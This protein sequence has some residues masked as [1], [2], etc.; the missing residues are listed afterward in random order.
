MSQTQSTS[1]VFPNCVSCKDAIL[2][3]GSMYV[4]PCG[5]PLHS[6]CFRKIP[7]PKQICPVCNG[8]L[9]TQPAKTTATTNVN[10]PPPIITRSRAQSQRALDFD[11]NRSN[12]IPPTPGNTQPTDHN[13]SYM[14]TGSPQGQQDQIQT[15]VSAAVSAQQ[16]AMLTSLTQHL[17]KLIET[18]IQTAFQRLNSNAPV[19]NNQTPNRAQ[20][21]VP[22]QNPQI[23]T[24][25]AVEQQTLEQL[26]GLSSNN[27]NQ[28]GPSTT[29]SGG[30]LSS[31]VS[32]RS[33][34]VGH[35]IH[36]WQIRFTGD[37]KGM[38]VENF[39]Y[40]VEALTRQT[41]GGNFDLLCDHMS[42][43][44][45]SKASDWFWRHHKSC[46]RIIWSDF[47]N[48]L[49][50]Q[51]NDTRT[52]VDYREMIRDRKQKPGEPFDTFYD[53]L[54]DISDRLATPLPERLLVEILRRNL[55]PE[56]QHELLNL[57][58]KSV[59]QLREICRKREFFLQDMGKMFGLSKSLV[60]RRQVHE[61]FQE[62][63]EIADEEISA[64]SLVCWNCQK[65]GHRYQE[66]LDDRR[67]FCY[68]CGTPNVYKPTCS[69]C[70][71]SKNVRPSALK[72]ARKQTRSMSTNT[73]Q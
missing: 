68:G 72:S 22:V 71:A 25:P 28:T 27:G 48:A 12:T 49:R 4:P 43:L 38:P 60:P 56:I 14:S 73:D 53:A 8:K 51:Y 52:D 47:C 13:V 23:L 21:T 9:I 24:L 3:S 55:Q 50:E 6:V 40:R 30:N 33:D 32:I 62:D 19:P 41:L 11:S 16:T 66:C 31:N 65:S 26:L 44:F 39:I 45:E 46:R 15:L 42:A 5:H 36:N 29:V 64:I 63:S 34:K 58:I 7:A 37:P 69:T 18:N 1:G 10:V 57:E 70:N 35:I 61:L 20:D 54:I 67:V 2:E 17:T 59:S